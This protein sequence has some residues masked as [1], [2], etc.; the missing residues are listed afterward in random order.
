MRSIGIRVLT[1]CLGFTT[2]L[3]AYASPLF[4]QTT[5]SAGMMRFPDVSR[6]RIVFC[7]ADDLWTV[8]R[9]G[10]I[11]TPLVSPVG[12]ELMP[13]FSPDGQSIAFVGNY[14]GLRDIYSISTQGGTTVRWTYHPADELL[15]DWH[16]DGKRL[17]YSTNG[18][19]GLERQLQLMTV[20][21]DQPLPQPIPVPYGSNGAISADGKWL[22]Y[23]PHSH[24]FRTW[25]RYRGGMASDVWLFSLENHASKQ[26]TDFEGTDSL[27]MW[28]GETVY[29][30]SDAGSEH[31][32][33]IWS[34]NTVSGERKQITNFDAFDSKW[35]AIGPGPEG[36][37][38]IIL[39]NGSRLYLVDLATGASKPVDV[40]IPGE[41]PRLRRQRVDASK[42]VAGVDVS[43][44]TKRLAVEARGDIW[45][46]PA[47]KG[48]PRNLTR[49]SGVAERFPA[50]SPDGQWIAYLADATGE[51]ELY[52]TQS[53]G[54]GATRQLTRNGD[55]FRYSPSWSPNSK[56]L[57]FSD[58][59]GAL[60]LYSFD[61][62][63]TQK[64]D[65]DPYAEPIGV[66]W[67]HN[68]QWLVYGRNSDDKSPSRPLWVYNIKDG[69]RRQITSGFFTDS[70]PV[71]DRKGEFI[72]FLTRRSFTSPT[73]D[74][75][76]TSF[77]YTDTEVIAGI[78]LR[79]DVKNPF[80]ATSD[81]ELWGEEKEKQE[82]KDKEKSNEESKG[83]SDSEKKD[84]GDPSGP[85]DSEKTP[86]DKKE[87][88][89][90]APEDKESEDKE[91]AA[92]DRTASNASPDDAA[93][94][95]PSE[96]KPVELDFTIDFENIERRAF[97]LPL[98]AGEYGALAVNDKHQLIYGERT[99]PPVDDDEED[100]P[101]RARGGAI[102]LFD[103]EDDKRKPKTIVDGSSQF[104]IT[105]D[106]KRLAVFR[107]PNEIFLIDAAA[108]QKLEK[109]VS[110]SGMVASIEPREEWRQLFLEAWR[111][112][113]DFFYDPT[114]HGVD[115]PA[116][117]DHYL[118]MLDDCVSRRDVGF[119]IS[120]MISELNVGHAY[121]GG[122][123]IDDG[124][125]G[126]VGLLGCR[127]EIDQGA[128]RFA[129]FEEGAEWDVDA[130]NPLRTAGI[131]IGE[132]LLAINGIPL[133]ADQDP[134]SYL[135]GM[136]GMTVVLTVSSDHEQGGDDRQ[137][138]VEALA[139]DSA[140]RF[141]RWIE[142]NRKYVA[143]RT[144]GK[145]GYIYVVN[146]GLPGQNDLV[147]QYFGQLNKEA[148]II[149]D[150]WNGG[151][152]I[153]TRFI[154]LLNRPV[155][156][157]WAKRD[158]RDWTWPPDAHHGPKCMLINGMA[159]SGGDMFPALFKQSKL[160]KLIGMRTW[161]GLVG[162]SGNPGLIDG[163]NVT[164]P[165]FAYY[166][167]DGTWGIE[168]HGVDPDLMVVDDPG[169]MSDG[170]DPQLDAA[171][172]QMKQELATQ[173]YVPAPRPPYPDRSKFGIRP[174][175]K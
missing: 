109:P 61:K 105:T 7:Y 148:L 80:L 139:S 137:V 162:I 18:Y 64:I 132:Y 12:Q 63:A 17:I 129:A 165:T 169:K 30:V 13:R 67:S 170:A 54:R 60:W 113:R 102:R 168:G 27:P 158:G 75:L 56:Y 24:D 164:A 1:H 98:P 29:Y 72:Y 14:D 45:T 141:R 103:F 175:D 25:K 123:D 125:R 41:R 146:T 136:A 20:S 174:S 112:E 51:Y 16:P 156:N 62:D 49:T 149:D 133:K 140:L 110:M 85:N 84:A 74:D 147:R 34:Y 55:Q 97:Q 21:R 117:R 150:R 172:E 128:Y 10:G 32:L 142:H 76:G 38:E 6:D 119:V 89:N 92:N 124:P 44:S 115:W 35:P 22:A 11:A 95:K 126:N 104:Q 108:D 144:D 91:P 65:V 120:E 31:R 106:G 19:A 82:K 81:E 173:R 9:E 5:P 69:S 42:Y 59:A 46:L 93:K 39:Q 2:G 77:V 101:E 134:S 73:Y 163:A 145:V 43:N 100:S 48:P 4:G 37:G 121:Y 58:K 160:G 166:E 79:P 167:L 28:H 66:S 131:K 83:T 114:M 138:P 96:Q 47:K 151:G 171:I 90:P 71:F 154:E 26:M 36:K 99:E 94:E 15:C 78:P 127:L 86:P 143:D 111:I 118:K 70:T 107:G 122:G 3:L 130:R 88:Q 23:T 33:N 87:S 159:G 161:G 155:T 53:D 40:T 116:V 153:P 8:S 152:Q 135:Q 50:W 57:T 157:Y 52:V 68:S